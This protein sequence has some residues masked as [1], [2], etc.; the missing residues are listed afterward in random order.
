[1][2]GNTSSQPPNKR[3]PKTE[4]ETIKRESPTSQPKGQK[5]E[6]EPENKTLAEVAENRG[7]PRFPRDG[8]NELNLAMIPRP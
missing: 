3:L 4:A 1:M 5:R 8:S 7:N 2:E 6:S